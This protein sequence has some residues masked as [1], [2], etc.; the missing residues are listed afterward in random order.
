MRNPQ[1]DLLRFIGLSMIIL[2]H[3]NPPGIV[4]ELRSFDV[5]LMVAV[6]GMAFSHSR[7]KH[8]YGAYL[9]SRILRLLVPVWI[10]VSLYFVAVYVSG[11]AGQ[12]LSLRKIVETYALLGGIGYV[13]IIRVFLV[14]AVVSPFVMAIVRHAKTEAHF[15]MIL[16]G[17]IL[18][19]E[20]VLRITK[21]LLHFE[22]FTIFSLFF[23]Y[24][25]IYSIIFGFGAR[26]TS[27]N[28]RLTWIF[29]IS[30]IV[31]FIGFTAY[32][33]YVEKSFLP[34]QNF[35]YPPSFYY[36]LFGISISTFLWLWSSKIDKVLSRTP[37]AYRAALFIGSHTI[38]IYLWHIPLINLFV[39]KH[40]ILSHCVHS[41]S[42]AWSGIGFLGGYVI[43]YGIATLIVL[44]QHLFVKNVVIPRLRS[45]TAKRN[46]ALIFI[47]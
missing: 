35:K 47:G 33:Y 3:V 39:G 9:W 42:G 46:V 20:I 38:W 11:Q 5:P 45:S 12:F 23:Y 29:A 19:Y 40:N 15:F 17:A 14:V 26:L 16:G 36:Y 32:Y 25:F 2:A 1:I 22:F 18:A 24:G 28:R 13:W 44:A 37:Q 8:D 41:T 21:P 4:F 31:V 6:S 27:M 43:V 7:R 34:L 30:L 10:F